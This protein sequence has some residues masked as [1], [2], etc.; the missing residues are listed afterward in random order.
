M[1][2]KIITHSKM[3]GKVILK[4]LQ[5]VDMSM[6]FLNIRHE[7]HK[8]VNLETTNKIQNEKLYIKVLVPKHLKNQNNS[9]FWKFHKHKIGLEI[10]DL[11]H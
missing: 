11:E 9:K 5:N 7:S 3:F 1:P 2:K 4:M 8:Y 10:F 6:K